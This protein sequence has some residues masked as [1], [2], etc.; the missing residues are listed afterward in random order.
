MTRDEGRG[1]SGLSY[2]GLVADLRAAFDAGVT[3][4]LAW[5]T[6]QLDALAALLR[7]H[8]DAIAAALASD[9]GKPA[10]ESFLTEVLATLTEVGLARRRLR[11]WL[12]PR[13]LRPSLATFPTVAWTVQEP[14]GV[15]L[16]IAPWN[17]PLNLAL[18]PVVGAL[19][20]GN[21]V[22]L[23]PSE[24]APATAALLAD[25]VPRYLDRRA[26]RVVTGGV[27]ETTALLRERYDH[28]FYTGNGRVGRIVARA[29]AEH[30]T[31]TTLEL[32]GKS[33]V[34][35]DGTTDLAIAADRLAW[36]K[37][38]NAGQTCVAPDYVLATPAAA[39]ELE[40]LL[41]EA[42]RRMFGD[43]PRRS[44][45]YGRIV[46]ADHHARLV[47]YLADGRLVSGGDHDDAALHLGPTVLADVDPASPVMQEEIFGPILPILRVPD[48]A[49]AIAFITAREKPLA[50]Y[51][52]SSDAATRRAF[53]EGTS[54]GALTFG[55]P[56]AHLAMPDVPFGGVG[57]SG[58]GAYHG[59][60]SLATFTRAKPVV[61]K[62]SRPDTL[63]LAYP[64]HGG[65]RLGL[66]RR[67]L[68]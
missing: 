23:K 28:I 21:A 60:H 68:G 38:T 56:M 26:V 54:S 29:A 6:G 42:A 20:G 47:G 40:R 25:L 49:A 64:P 41:P 58:M 43:D 53:V 52:F 62:P 16:V 3:R 46:S 17:Y 61:S 1:A 35:L 32:G 44:P 8:E 51:V 15:C 48:A 59:H 7:E 34:F 45:D 11:W 36:A 65:R 66:L 31:P 12:R 5:R 39:D 2:A 57:E 33:P 14:L 30:L 18:T 10:A 50:L 19:A 63:R 27:P 55:L 37:W 24:L 4:P 13:P 22:V 67:A 9:L